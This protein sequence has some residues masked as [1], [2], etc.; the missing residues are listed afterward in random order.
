MQLFTNFI[1][2]DIYVCNNDIV[3]LQKCL[4]EI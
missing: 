3:E 1:Q 4:Q 2:G